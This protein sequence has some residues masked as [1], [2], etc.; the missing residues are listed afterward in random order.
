MI[1]LLLSRSCRSRPLLFLANLLI[2]FGPLVFLGIKQMKGYEPGYTDGG[3]R[4]DDVRGQ[5]EP[6][7]DVT[8]VISLWQSGEEFRKAAPCLGSCPQGQSVP[9][10]GGSA[11]NSPFVRRDKPA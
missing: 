4:L 2:L 11:G 10:P 9:R 6:K 5:A 8:S 1:P 3:V 7:E